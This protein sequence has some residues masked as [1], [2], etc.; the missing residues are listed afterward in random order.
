MVPF[1][2]SLVAETKHNRPL[3]YVA[4]RD[5]RIPLDFTSCRWYSA[6]KKQVST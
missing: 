6:R 1:V 4:V 5:A 3:R 2:S